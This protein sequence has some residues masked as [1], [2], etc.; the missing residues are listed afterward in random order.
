MSHERRPYRRKPSWALL[1]LMLLVVFVFFPVLSTAGEKATASH[2]VIAAPPQGPEISAFGDTCSNSIS[3]PDCIVKFI[4]GNMF[5][6]CGLSKSNG[7]CTCQNAGSSCSV[8]GACT[9]S[10]WGSGGPPNN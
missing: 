7:F 6:Y 1:G 10:G 4:G 5:E 9:Y 8:T 3:C 2:P